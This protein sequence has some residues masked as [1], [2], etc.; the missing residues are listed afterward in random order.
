MSMNF[1]TALGEIVWN[2]DSKGVFSVKSVYHMT[3]SLPFGGAFV[4]WGKV[5]EVLKHKDTP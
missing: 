3:T 1:R 4:V 5:E 2:L